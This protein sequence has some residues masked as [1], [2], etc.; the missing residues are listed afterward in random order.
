MAYA[1]VPTG[2]RGEGSFAPA[3]GDPL[4]ADSS[5]LT[6][7]LA[8]EVAL[9]W[10]VAKGLATGSAAADAPLADLTCVHLGFGVLAANAAGPGPDGLEARDLCFALAVQAVAC[11]LTPRAIRRWL[12]PEPGGNFAAACGE[13]K[14]ARAELSERLG[15]P[16]REA[17]PGAWEH[18][19]AATRP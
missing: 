2:A 10:C 19:A 16:P 13:L 5:R 3:A 17:W 15:L 12:D 1:R 14:D 4:L 6:G 11:G 18:P 7:V 8:R 9:A